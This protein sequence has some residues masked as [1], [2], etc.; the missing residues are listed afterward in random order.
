MNNYKF[1]VTFWYTPMIEGGDDFAKRDLA[2]TLAE[3]GIDV[4]E[5]DIELLDQ[6]PA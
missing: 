1:R 2:T 5:N 4:S 3:A 6:E